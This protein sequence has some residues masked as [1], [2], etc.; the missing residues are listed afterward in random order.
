M[1][2]YDYLDSQNLIK[3][4]KDIINNRK[5]K[6]LKNTLS[7][8]SINV[9]KLDNSESESEEDDIIVQTEMDYNNNDKNKKI[10]DYTEEN[11]MNNEMSINNLYE[12]YKEQLKDY[13]Y[14]NDEIE[15]LKL[16]GY[17][18]YINLSE[19]LRFG[20]ILIAINE[21]DN[22]FKMRLVLKNTTN[23]IW[24]ISYINNYIF[25][26][27]HKTKNDKF[28]NLFLKVAMIE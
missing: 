21:K 14:I 15:N 17:V 3:K 13:F 20:G 10:I 19:E 28:R 23:N 22:L 6:E 1:D 26:K 27:K 4:E 12:K 2:I 18:R 11:N 7:K 24:E 16:G 25:Y 5:K 9:V 8:Y